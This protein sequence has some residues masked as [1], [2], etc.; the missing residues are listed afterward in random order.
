MK[1]Y[2]IFEKTQFIFVHFHA[3]EVEFFN[4]PLLVPAVNDPRDSSPR[5]PR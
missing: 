3:R 5:P 1:F 2:M 4:G